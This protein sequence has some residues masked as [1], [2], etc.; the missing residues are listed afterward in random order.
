MAIIVI[1][2]AI[3]ETWLITKLSGRIQELSKYIQ[4]KIGVTNEILLDIVKMT[5]FI[6]IFS[7]NKFIQKKYNEATTDV[8][9]ESVKRNNHILVIEGISELLNAVNLV[10]I[11]CLGIWMYFMQ[12]VDLGSVMAFLVLQDG[13][14]YMF[15]NLGGVI[16][17]IHQGAASIERL[18][19]LLDY[20]MEQDSKGTQSPPLNNE[21][22]IRGKN[23]NFQYNEENGKVLDQV[24]FT[25]FPHSV[26]TITGKSGSGKST[27]VKLLMGFYQPDSGDII[28]NGI[29]Y[30]Q[31]Q[32]QD[33]RDLYAYVGQNVYL[34]YDTI[35]ENIRCGNQDATF[36]EVVA[37]A[38]LAQAHDFI[39]EKE[40]GYATL[41]R[42][43]GANFSGGQKQR[44]AIARAILRNAPVIIWDE[45]TSAIDDKTEELIHKYLN[46][47][48]MK[49]KT[50]IVVAHKNSILSISDYEL[51]LENGKF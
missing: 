27:F 9:N 45:A 43:H 4:E 41:I 29:P 18:L 50:V 36:E 28:V 10:G 23:L 21:V 25:L 31:M 30:S 48:K 34:F 51:R 6:R 44:I 2:F 49:G 3:F 40:Q 5:K 42:E 13:I 16:P 39:E 1:A 11:L 47:Q 12:V 32:L 24:N 8:V 20:P 33:I 15:Q 19:D 22:T 38:K 46:D 37:A 35:E 26:T 7:I 17:D 14:T